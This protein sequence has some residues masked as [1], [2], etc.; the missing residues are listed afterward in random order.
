MGK[1]GDVAV[2]A[3][4]LLRSG[5]NSA[6]EA[7]ARMAEAVFAGAPGCV[8]KSCP[9]EAF[10]GLCQA[11]LL[12]GV[13]ASSCRS[14]DSRANRLYARLTVRLLDAEPGLAGGSRAEIWRLVMR[15]SGADPHKRSNGQIDVVLALWNKR[16]IDP[17]G[18]PAG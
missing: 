18:R 5:H 2:R 7:W 11:G 13:P 3:T 17:S 12:A 10:L 4:E 1:Y 9:R 6:E 8:R 16:M 15:A 14:V